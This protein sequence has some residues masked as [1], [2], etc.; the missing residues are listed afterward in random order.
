MF[1]N[2]AMMYIRTE[3]DMPT[4]SLRHK[5]VRIDQAKLNRAK[6]VLNAETDTEAL[7]R[8]LDVVVAEAQIDR[9]L[10]AVRGKGRLRKVFP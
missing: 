2:H 4:S 3:Y 9:A 1:M 10:R 7:D 5:H 6:R 8:A